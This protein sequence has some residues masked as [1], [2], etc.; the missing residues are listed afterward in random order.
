MDEIVKPLDHIPGRDKSK[1]IYKP[2]NLLLEANAYHFG[3]KDKV[4]DWQF[5]AF[6]GRLSLK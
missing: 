5:Y 3:G 4:S 2:G 6:F 1:M